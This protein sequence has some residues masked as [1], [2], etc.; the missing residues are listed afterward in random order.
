MSKRFGIRFDH[1]TIHA[2]VSE[3]DDNTGKMTLIDTCTRKVPLT[4]KEREDFERVR[5]NSQT[6]DRRLRNGSRRN[7]QRFLLRKRQLLQLLIENKFID[8]DT[9][10]SECE[11]KNVHRTWEMRALAPV[12][13]IPLDD[14]ARVFIMM[15]KHRGYKETKGAKDPKEGSVINGISATTDMLN[16]GM[17][18]G[19]YI[20]HLREMGSQIEPTFYPTELKEE[21]VRIITTQRKYHDRIL[22]DQTATILF[23]CPKKR[24]AA[25]LSEHKMTIS[26]KKARKDELVKARALAV[27]EE[28]K[29]ELMAE[30]IPDII[31][32]I[33]DASAL[34][35]QMSDRSKDAFLAGQTPGQWIWE[36]IKKEGN[37]FNTKSKTFF[38]SDYKAEFETIWDVQSKYHPELTDEL[39]EKIMNHV[40]YWQRDLKS[41][42]GGYCPFESFKMLVNDP[43]TGEAYIKTVGCRTAPKSSPLFQEFRMMND[44]ANL[45]YIDDETGV[46]HPFT[47]EMKMKVANVLR[48]TKKMTPGAVLRAAGLNVKKYSL[49]FKEISGNI[50]LAEIH[51]TLMSVA[52]D[53]GFKNVKDMLKATG[54]CEQLGDYRWDLPKEEYEKQPL[55]RLWILVDSYNYDDSVTGMET[56]KRQIE[57]RFNTDDQTSEA[58]SM[59]SFPTGHGS[60]S[61]KAM[62]KLLL[63]LAEGTGYYDACLAEGY[64]MTETSAN[65]KVAMEL[66]EIKQ[67]QLRNPIA[68]KILN[69]VIQ[70][71]NELIQIHGN[72]DITIVE[73]PRSLNMNSKKRK[74]LYDFIKL[75]E[76]ENKEYIS[77]IQEITGNPNVTSRQILRYRLY[78]EL[79]ENGYRTLYSDRKID[80]ATLLKTDLIHKEHII[81]QSVIFEDNYINLTLEYADVDNDKG[82]M[83]A[84]DFVLS[85]YGQ[86]GLD[87]YLQTV[88]MLADKK[89]ISLAKYR[90]LTMTKGEVPNNILDHQTPARQYAMKEFA[91]ML[92]LVS[93]KVIYSV[94][95]VT[96]KIKKDWNLEDIMTEINAPDYEKA[97]RVMEKTTSD[98]KKYKKI[99]VRD[100]VASSGWIT[101]TWTPTMDPRYGIVDAVVLS[102]T[103]HQH[104]HYLNNLA[105]AKESGSY[106]W[107]IRKELTTFANGK[108]VFK[109]P[110]P[111]DELKLTIKTLI[112]RTLVS[113][114]P[115]G[116]L[117]NRKRNITKTKSNPAG[118]N[119]QMTL[120]PR[121]QLH[122]ETV[123]KRIEI[124][125]DYEIRLSA[126]TSMD[127]IARISDAKVKSAVF[128]RLE[129]HGYSVAEA[130]GGSN[131]IEKNPVWIDQANNVPVPA[132]IRCT[133]MEPRYIVR[134]AINEDLNVDKVCDRSIQNALKARIQLK[135]SMKAAVEDI[136]SNP[137][138]VDGKR[139]NRVLIMESFR[140]AVP[141]R[142]KRNHKG[143]VI[144]DAEGNPIPCDYVLPGDNH[145]VDF[146]ITADGQPKSKIMT[147]MECINRINKNESPYD[148]HHKESEGWQ[149]RLSLSKANAVIFADP[150]EGFFPA[151]MT[152]EELQNHPMTSINLYYLQKMS[153][154]L[155]VFRHHTDNNT[156]IDFE[157]TDIKL[158]NIGGAKG[159]KKLIGMVKVRINH[160]GRIT[161]ILGTM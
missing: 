148:I 72:P 60:L 4:P 46:K 98:G 153:G 154:D 24:A 140:S 124:P 130:F 132:N 65:G 113:I 86:K 141:V 34:L 28:I 100:Y 159:S 95:A 64:N 125:V 146:Y 82:D 142:V 19:Q 78:E 129:Q 36:K 89:A 147:F 7:R 63:H 57:E 143:D 25:L 42:K 119:E 93:Y 131:M 39:K 127:D 61:H 77:K 44:I 83:P 48:Y 117:V 29:A 15:N 14:L 96:Q 11:L 97:G 18:P 71:I 37:A 59:M 149:Y 118:R 73:L 135:G 43:K 2:A 109:T 20:L 103:T 6:E 69:Q 55:I 70:V 74:E 111:P 13:E 158:K 134:T 102:M 31:G 104:I 53:K 17:T 76:K 75:R 155:F 23:D 156:A 139:V 110:M 157:L 152:V 161:H 114:K 40:I 99:T 91:N 54:A 3:V 33:N 151:S 138:I 81:P 68:E 122:Q 67:N 160:I 136:K 10:L 112:E 115:D 84:R 123:Y 56:L 41:V 150:D 1:N 87:R 62:K 22:N 8:E 50:T 52:K 92:S 107:K 90:Y 66:P 116:R 49:N 121:G 35:G 144:L 128:K 101:R 32:K 9:P 145:H 106:F 126:R 80:L 21:L 79:K 45:C 108:R 85:R 94:P 30:I 51:G 120:V 47:A 137:L 26:E 88:K 105:Q 27:T 38:R 58:L 16:K 133:K 12:R 5:N